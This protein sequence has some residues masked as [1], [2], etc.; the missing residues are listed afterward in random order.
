MDGRSLRYFALLQLIVDYL[1]QVSL[2]EN[3]FLKDVGGARNDEEKFTFAKLHIW[4]STAIDRVVTDPQ[5]GTNQITRLNDILLT[6]RF[7]FVGQKVQVHYTKLVYLDADISVVKN[8]DHLFECGNGLCGQMGVSN[9]SLL[10]NNQTLL[11][12]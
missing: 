2:I 12:L 1:C 8:I 10:Q 6:S 5:S 7:L 9:K 4:N 11:Y 3:P